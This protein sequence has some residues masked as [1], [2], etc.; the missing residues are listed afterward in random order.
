MV[1]VLSGELVTVIVQ[2]LAD[3]AVNV[4]ERTELVRVVEE[5]ESARDKQLIDVLEVSPRL[6][7]PVVPVDEGEGDRAAENVV[8]AEDVDARLARA[9]GGKEVVG[10]ERVR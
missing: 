1:R 8:T 6:L 3:N 7:V 4:R 5:D 2:R 9:P 10:S